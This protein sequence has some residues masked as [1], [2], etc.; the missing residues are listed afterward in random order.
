LTYQLEYKRDGSGF[1]ENGRAGETLGARKLVYRGNSGLWELADSDS[2]SS[3]PSLGITLSQIRGGDRG[4]ILTYGYVGDA[5]WTF[6]VGGAIYASVT[7]GELTQ[8]S[9]ASGEQ[10]IIG[11]A[12]EANLI[13]FTPRRPTGSENATYLKTMQVST[14][15]LGRPNTN[16]P[17]VVDKD[18]VTL[19]SFTVNT[20][21]MTWKLAKPVDY[22]S[23]TLGF[24]VVWTNNGGKDDD[25]ETVKVQIDY[26][27]ASEG[28]VIEGSHANSPKTVEDAYVS[29]VGWVEHHTAFVTIAEADFVNEE[30]LFCKVSFV[31][32][33]GSALTCEPHLI[34]ICLQYLASP[35]R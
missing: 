8:I 32:P 24:S 26:Q 33:T 21:H 29:A 7:A 23:G 3:M 19:Y 20:D 4:K 2:V 9:P 5:T 34:G 17:T 30:C 13:H 12:I 1:Y 31:T 25:G 15:S 6:N 16:P 11:Y 18:N 14:D 10:Q 22:V 35:D 27:V 28:G